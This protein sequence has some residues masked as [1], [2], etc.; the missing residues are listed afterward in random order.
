V[1]AGVLGELRPG[2][3]EGVFA[4]LPRRQPGA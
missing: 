3:A 2:V 1:V 4:G